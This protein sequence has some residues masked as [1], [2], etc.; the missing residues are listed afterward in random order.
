MQEQDTYEQRGSGKLPDV[1]MLCVATQVVTNQQFVIYH[2]VGEDKVLAS[3][4]SGFRTRYRLKEVEVKQV[5]EVE[6][7]PERVI[8]LVENGNGV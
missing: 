5:E 7:R 4:L 6:A 3:T 2:E 1:K 8:N